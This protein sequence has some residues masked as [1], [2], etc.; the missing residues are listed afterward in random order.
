MTLGC[1][2]VN[3][4]AWWLAGL[5][6][7][8]V[9]GNFASAAT[10]PV[11]SAIPASDGILVEAGNSAYWWIDSLGI[12]HRIDSAGNVL[13]HVEF[14][15]RNAL[16]YLRHGEDRFVAI[17]VDHANVYDR[18]L[19]LLSRINFPPRIK[20]NVALLHTA[21]PHQSRLPLYV[22]LGVLVLD[23]DLGKTDLVITAEPPGPLA[24]LLTSLD[25]QLLEVGMEAAANSGSRNFTVNSISA[26]GEIV[27]K[28][29]LLNLGGNCSKDLLP[30]P[31]GLLMVCASV[32]KGI[33]TVML[34]RRGR[35]S[36][37]DLSSMT[38]SAG[39]SSVSE[40]QLVLEAM[41][42]PWAIQDSGNLLIP[43]V[44]VVQLIRSESQAAQ[45]QR[46]LPVSAG[47]AELH[48]VSTAVV[49][50][51]RGG[52][53]HWLMGDQNRMWVRALSAQPVFVESTENALT[54]TYLGG[55]GLTLKDS[56]DWLE[57]GWAANSG[58][59]APVSFQ[60]SQAANSELP[61]VMELQVRK[62]GRFMKMGGNPAQAFLEF[63]KSI[64]R[65]AQL[66][67]GMDSLAF[68]TGGI[69]FTS[70]QSLNGASRGL[71]KSPTSLGS[72]AMQTRID[73]LG[74]VLNDYMNPAMDA[75][76]GG[77]AA[78]VGNAAWANGIFYFLGGDTGS[79]TWFE[80]RSRTRGTVAGTYTSLFQLDKA[81]YAINLQDELW[82][83]ETSGARLL[84]KLTGLT[85]VKVEGAQ[86]LLL[87]ERSVSLQNGVLRQI[88]IPEQIR[89]ASL[90]TDGFFVTLNG[91]G[92]VRSD[93]AEANYPGAQQV[94]QFNNKIFLLHSDGHA[95]L[96]KRDLSLMA[97]VHSVGNGLVVMTPEGYFSGFGSYLDFLNVVQSSGARDAVFPMTQFFDIF[98]RPDI[99]RAKLL[100]DDDYVRKASQEMTLEKALRSP[101]PV[102]SIQAP[103]AVV[104][105]ERVRLSYTLRSSGGGVG[106]ILVFHNGK[107]VKSDGHYRDVPGSTL[108]AIN[109][110]KASSADAVRKGQAKLLGAG[111]STSGTASG[112]TVVVRQ[113]QAK[114]LNSAGEYTNSIEIDVLPGEVNEVTVLGRNSENTLLGLGQTVRFTSTLA[115]SEPHLWL[116]PVGIAKFADAGVRPLASPRKDALDFACFYGGREALKNV[117]IVCN[118]IGYATTVFKPSQVHM[119]EPLFNERATRANILAKLDEIAQ[120]SRPGDTFVWF[121]SSHGT[122]D[123]NSVYGIVPFDAK[124]QD[125]RCSGATGLIS[126]NDILERS[127]A[128]RAMKQLV[129]L[130]TC[131]AGGL[132]NKM[133]GLYDARMSGLAKNMG[134]HLYAAA[135]ATEVAL[136]GVDASRNS[137]FTASLLEGLSG[138]AIDRNGD[139]AISVMELGSFAKRRT[140]ET[141]RSTYP[142]LVPANPV[143]QH[144]GRDA[145]L[146]LQSRH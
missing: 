83:I 144:F 63:R 22:D 129:I 137:L 78:T 69:Q 39:S 26:E 75:V 124:C 92:V 32:G 84:A 120:K 36:N 31:S 64:G 1:S 72:P 51:D 98:H 38:L 28:Y 93:R 95:S 131:H 99:V 5:V 42:T 81:I 122:V 88:R 55:F 16:R 87:G 110:T 23:L 91:G 79:I 73:G 106:E 114:P 143:I 109:T 58:T 126:S 130:D 107:L 34:G 89:D 133:S 65:L 141:S 101:P 111:E 85:A 94:F 30:V 27:G 77:Q 52:N 45:V 44:G 24:S 13:R 119:L 33:K 90:S 96:L 54:A 138:Q 3:W 59:Q 80:P 47:M 21:M 2:S 12:G 134:L 46:V 8:A 86:A 40:E 142:D 7:I 123:A 74:T 105:T 53:L 100:G 17:H 70:M 121:V 50:R 57:R 67:S 127:K 135:T 60:S 145:L 61:G 29:R 49:T 15:E 140:P 125:T 18:E 115:K 25:G 118:Q 37:I 132:D 35:V 66:D 116:L 48:S 68:Q 117:G 128:I 112:G 56:V 9:A 103:S 71:G 62:L 104:T 146:T 11:L 76:I 19:K 136:D 6:W 82:M 41:T 4:R 10:V 97:T 14:G 139:G 108:V 113:A 20:L 43:T 102:V